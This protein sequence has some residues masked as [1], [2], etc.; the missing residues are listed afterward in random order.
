M[1]TKCRCLFQHAA[2]AASVQCTWGKSQFGKPDGLDPLTPLI[3]QTHR[4]GYRF[5]I[6]PLVQ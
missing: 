3:R 6:R 1:R 4:A 2:E 5:T